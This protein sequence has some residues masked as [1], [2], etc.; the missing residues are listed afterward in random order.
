MKKYNYIDLMKT[1]GMFIVVAVH[2]TLFYSGNDFWPIRAEQESAI[3]SWLSNA[4]LVSSVPIFVF[5]AGF[6]LQVSLQN[7]KNSTAQL[8]RKK[9]VR[10]LIPYFIYGALWLVPTY[11]LFDIPSYGRDK[12]ASLL[13]GYKAMALGE[14]SDVAWFLMMLFWVT[15]IWVLLNGLLSRKNIIYGAAV[16]VLLYLAAH[17][18]LVQVDYFKLSQIDIY[19]VVFFAGAA[20]FCLIDYLEKRST[21]VLIVSS[22]VGIVA[23]AFLAQL[24][25]EMYF[26]DCLLRIVS[27]ALLL[28]LCMGLCRTGVIARMEQTPTYNWLR[29]NSLYMY[30][31]QAPGMYV[32]FKLVNPVLGA[33]AIL[34]FLVQFVLTLLLDVILTQGYVTVKGY[35]KLGSKQP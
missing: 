8:I 1:M 35:I 33:N 15:L 7:K 19:I 22:S 25:P 14:F 27:P 3:L 26:L 29:K 13:A 31:L 34:C 11:T 30:L 4:I 28:I 21:V 17:F 24:S 23:C 10:L 18:L 5:A 16:S 2:C 9:A 6:L 32:V 12:G 20:L